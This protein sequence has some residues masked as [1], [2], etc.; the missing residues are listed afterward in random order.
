MTP[1]DRGVC[2][3]PPFSDAPP[4]SPPVRPDARD[5]VVVGADELRALRRRR[6]AA[7]T[8]DA[9]TALLAAWRAVL[10]T[11][12]EIVEDLEHDLAREQTAAEN[13]A[14]S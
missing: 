10:A 2:R 14:A 4:S 7:E 13:G 5:L 8:T 6:A 11:A 9:T 1:N 3:F 12:A